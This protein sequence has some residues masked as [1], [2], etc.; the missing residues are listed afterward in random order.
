MAQGRSS[1]L[2]PK[3]Q[4]V[5]L[6]IPDAH[7]HPDFDNKRFDALGQFAHDLDPDY[8]VCLGDWYDMPS[9]NKHDPVGS[10]PQLDACYEDD[11]KAG[12][13]ALYRFHRAFRRTRAQLHVTYG[14]HDVRPDR[15]A[16]DDPKW[17]GKVSLKDLGFSHHKW[18]LTPYR[19]TLS[20]EG[21]VFT[22]HATSGVAGRPIGG[23]HMAATLVKK[24]HVSMVVGHSHTYQHFEHTKGNGDKIFGLSAGCW[25][26]QDYGN[27][28]YSKRDN[29]CKDTHEYWWRGVVV[30]TLDGAGYYRRISAIQMR[31]IL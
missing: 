15:A 20:L 23:E 28:T 4:R 27:S 31:D 8:I 11:I 18:H 29:W 7:A 21:I 30:M 3:G 25:V 19:S 13:D 2:R 22:H 1:R 24:K 17:R 26:H 14:N 10:L 12:D 16:S 9:L 6:V 5:L